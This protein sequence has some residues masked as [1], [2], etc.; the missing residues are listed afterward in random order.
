M[1]RQPQSLSARAKLD[2]IVLG[3]LFLAVFLFLSW[4]DAFEYVV[5]VMER[6]EDW[7]LDEFIMAVSLLGF[8]GFIFSLR[9]YLDA[10]GELAK[11]EVAEASVSWLSHYDPLTELPNRRLLNEFVRKFDLAEKQNSTG[12]KYVVYSLD[13]DGFK[14]VNDLHGHL[15]GDQLLKTV[16]NRLTSFFPD[17][18]VVRLAGDEFV[19]IARH[20]D[21]AVASQVA[22][23][24]ASTLT[25]PIFIDGKFTEVGT[26]IGVVL[27]PSQVS[28]LEE[29]LQCGDIAMY[30]AKKSASKQVSIFREELRDIAKAKATFERQLR[31]ALSVDAIVPFYQPLVDLKTGDVYGFEVLARWHLPTGEEVSPSVFIPLAEDAGLISEL[32]EKLLRKA[33]LEAVSWPQHI[34][35]SFNLSPTQ[36]SDGLIGLRIVNIL[37]ETGFAPTRLEIEITESAIIG[38]TETAVLIL[39][40][41]QNLGIKIA[42]DDFGTGYSSLS[43]M[44]KFKFDRLKIDQ[45]FVR[46]FENDDRQNSIVK[47]II[48]L[49]HGLSIA[50]TA[51]GIEEVSQLAALKTLGCDAGQGYLL[52]RPMPAEL[53]LRALSSASPQKAKGASSG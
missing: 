8:S 53:A 12:D 48:A 46:E 27:Y 13:L 7:Q 28:T 41:L 17:D 3:I 49:G 18:L 19:V 33:C 22:L 9:R 1:N 34:R 42:L 24:L 29:A 20:K 38:D 45:S 4:V 32:S 37:N 43:Q 23:E 50:T 40:E 14:K 11:R 15:A 6:H 25:E 44:S 51:E 52:G 26:S 21:G 5:R 35:L 47:A 16:S 10:K 31:Y 39:D 30:D 36:L 2:A